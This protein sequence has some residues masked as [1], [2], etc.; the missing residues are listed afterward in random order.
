VER[1]A[2][3]N[4]SGMPHRRR[5]DRHYSSY[6]PC[7]ATFVCGGRPFDASLT[8]HALAT[9]FVG[10]P[11][12]VPGHRHLVRRRGGRRRLNVGSQPPRQLPGTR[13]PCRRACTCR[14]PAYLA[15]V[16]PRP[17]LQAGGATFSCC[18]RRLWGRPRTA[19]LPP[20]PASAEAQT[21]TES[22]DLIIV[23][24]HPHASERARRRR[25]RLVGS[26]ATAPRID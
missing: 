11:R 10:C 24:L 9:F 2:A 1:G 13:W 6:T 8:G 5:S 22:P 23:T 14:H 20:L 7:R 25:L 18:S 21:L 19:P 3:L 17:S 4:L 12:L 26:R 15:R 16:A